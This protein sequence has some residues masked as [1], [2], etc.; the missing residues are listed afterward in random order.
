MVVD[1]VYVLGQRVVEVAAVEDQHSVEQLAADGADPAFGDRVRP[2]R[3]HRCAQDADALAGEHGIEDVGEL[4]V[5]IPDEEPDVCHAI[6][7]VGQQIP[8]LLSNPGSAG[9]RRGAQKVDA[10]G[11][12]L[13]HEQH[14]KPVTQ[15]GVDAEEVGGEN[16]LCWGGEELSPGGAAAARCGIDAG[17]L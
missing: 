15:Q 1:V 11:G 5:A 14:G 16:A 13:H 8:R 12:V 4:A 17:S 2:G 6:A 10:A 3:P 9:V 7:E